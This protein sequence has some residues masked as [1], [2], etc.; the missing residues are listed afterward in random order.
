MSECNEDA[1]MHSVIKNM[2]F[3]GRTSLV[4]KPK[5]LHLLR[6]VLYQTRK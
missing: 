3:N 1:L 4:K 6:S 5:T 2:P